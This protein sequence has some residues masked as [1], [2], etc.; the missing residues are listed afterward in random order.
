MIYQVY[1]ASFEKRGRTRCAALRF[2]FGL[3]FVTE[4]LLILV[5]GVDYRSVKADYIEY[6]CITV[7]STCRSAS[8]FPASCRS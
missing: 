4:V 2:F 1:Y 8:W 3:L 7:S 5:F 6:T